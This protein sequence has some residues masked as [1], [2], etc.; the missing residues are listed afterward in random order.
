MDLRFTWFYY[1]L[2]DQL[3]DKKYDCMSLS[4]RDLDYDVQGEDM[5]LVIK[6]GPH[7][8]PTTTKRQT[9]SAET[10]S[11]LHQARCNIYKICKYFTFNVK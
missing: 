2:S 4:Q 3:I 8:T 1:E 10:I 6:V 7:S 11:A 9:A 5:D